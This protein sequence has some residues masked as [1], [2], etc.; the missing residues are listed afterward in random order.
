MNKTLII[1]LLCLFTILVVS[2][3]AVYA[4]IL[5]SINYEIILT[6]QE[7]GNI[8]VKETILLQSNIDEPIFNLYFWIQNEAK[9]VNILVNGTEYSY[10]KDE[11]RYSINV[12]I[13]K[14]KIGEQVTAE[15][16]YLLDKD[17]QNFEKI[18]FQKTH[19]MIVT[20]DEKILYS[21]LNFQP[22]THLITPIYKTVESQ[23]ESPL[24]Y[25][26]IIIVLILI[27]LIFF[28]YSLKLKKTPE[29][30][31]IFSE[32]KELLTTK[33]TLLMS[34]LKDLEKQY[35][36]KEISDDTYHK[37]KE[38]YKQET[39]KTMKKLDDMMKSKV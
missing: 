22:G 4:Q 8:K 26:I 35:R 36:A 25:Y 7:D 37:L 9:N 10:T 29:T 15:I 19:S 31:E 23:K 17:I 18:L 33:K 1:S 38:Q 2:P 20:Y 24:L 27:I 13:L 32:T 3:F 14:I 16:T 28:F 12:T 21:G 34:L 30:K 39:V 11:T 5:D 6:T